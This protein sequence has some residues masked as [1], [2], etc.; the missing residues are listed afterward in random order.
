MRGPLYNLQREQLFA[1]EQQGKV[2]VLAPED[3]G[4]FKRT[5]SDAGAILALYRQGRRVADAHMAALRQYLSE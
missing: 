2:F 4:R 3:T 5:E 1:R